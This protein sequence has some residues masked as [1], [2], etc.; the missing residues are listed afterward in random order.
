LLYASSTTGIASSALVGTNVLFKSG[1]AGAAPAASTVTDNGSLLS[2]AQNGIISQPSVYAGSF[3]MH[4]GTAVSVTTGAVAHMA[5]TSVTGYIVTEPGA[6]PAN[7]NMMKSYSAIS[8]NNTTE[9]FLQAPRK[10]MLSSAYTNAT[11]T[12]STILSFTVDA[13]T[14][15]VVRC[16]GTYKAATGGAFVLTVTGPAT[17][18]L[19][20]YDFMPAVGLASGTPTFYDVNAT[21]S[22]YPS[23]VG[24]GAV[25]TA[26]TD[27]PWNLELGYTNGTT[28]GT[29]AIQ[30]Q[31]IST[32]TLTVEAGSY[33]QMQ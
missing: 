20:Q 21:G 8:S 16:H 33:C 19:V 22:A 26:A 9:S 32:N 14:S 7:N 25:T 31:T 18:T 5:P 13:S 23:A 4:Q 10:A 11:A 6:G 29:L 15:Y 12:A 27:M 1:G 2:T 3:V 28:A 30:G 24:S 17:P